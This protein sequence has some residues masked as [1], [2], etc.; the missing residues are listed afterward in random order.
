VTDGGQRS[1]GRT[2]FEVG[3]LSLFVLVGV[4]VAVGAGIKGEPSGIFFGL[5]FG[6]F[7]GWFA[8]RSIRNYLR[9]PDARSN[10]IAKPAA[11]PDEHASTG[12]AYRT[13]ARAR[14][15]LLAAYGGALESLPVPRVERTPGQH[16]E[17][18][19]SRTGRQ[20]LTTVFVALFAVVW[21]AVAWPVAIGS[22]GANSGFAAIF[23]WL[24]AAVGLLIVLVAF[25][26]FGTWLGARRAPVVE[27]S[28]EPLAPGD[29]FEVLV[30]Q[31]GPVRVTSYELRLI[32]EE[33]VSW[34]VGDSTNSEAATVFDRALFEEGAFAVSRLDGWKRSVSAAI[35]ELAMH[36]FKAPHNDVEWRLV[37]KAALDGWPDFEESYALRVLPAPRR[38]AA[39]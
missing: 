24:F 9:P 35:P 37:V 11:D 13:T 22:F 33:R 29:A 7:P 34:T 6:G 2:L 4:S 38:S 32:C 15:D 20:G 28:R 16:L 14:F 3:L 12:L 36:S 8:V 21:N 25:L 5:L 31:R 30:W 1:F 27:L 23:P 39:P 26:Q 17:L 18:R 10:V 19:L